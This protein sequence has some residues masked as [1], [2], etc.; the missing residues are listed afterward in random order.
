MFNRTVLLV[1]QDIE[2][3]DKNQIPGNRRRWKTLCWNIQAPACTQ[4]GGSGRGG[5]PGL[6]VL[7][8]QRLS[9]EWFLLMQ[10]SYFLKVIENT[11][12]KW[13][14]PGRVEEEQ[15]G[16]YPTGGL[17]ILGYLPASLV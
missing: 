10:K 5:S 4:Y 13:H 9:P 11:D 1:L 6:Y 12:F 8:G 3:K 14:F 15:G 17:E 7:W 16:E 2:K